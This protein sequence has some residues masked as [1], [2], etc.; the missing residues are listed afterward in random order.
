LVLAPVILVLVLVLIT[1][2]VLVGPGSGDPGC[3]LGSDPCACHGYC[4]DSD[5]GSVPGSGSSFS[6]G[7]DSVSSLVLVLGCTI[8][9]NDNYEFQIHETAVKILSGKKYAL[10]HHA[11]RCWQGNIPTPVAL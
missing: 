1:V 10:S 2:L 6:P 7:P 9:K 8:N 11:L 5:P 4:L 3:G